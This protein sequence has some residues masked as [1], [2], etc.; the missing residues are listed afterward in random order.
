MVNKTNKE[1]ELKL[2]REIV[3]YELLDRVAYINGVRIDERKQADWVLAVLSNWN[4]K[5]IFNGGSDI[6]KQLIHDA[7]MTYNLQKAFQLKG[8]I[9][10]HQSVADAIIWAL[11]RIGDVTGDDNIVIINEMIN[12]I[13]AYGLNKIKY[14]YDEE[15]G[16]FCIIRPYVIKSV[17]PV[18]RYLEELRSSLWIKDEL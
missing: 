18:K 16:F 2:I 8:V 7:G 10:H 13:N 17:D 6:L 9:G 11:S 14:D 15:N 12:T 5:C 4:A 3:D 1:Q